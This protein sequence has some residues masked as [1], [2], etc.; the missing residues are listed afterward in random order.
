MIQ[1]EIIVLNNPWNLKVRYNVPENAA[2]LKGDCCKMKVSDDANLI[3]TVRN[4]IVIA[5]PSLSMLL[6]NNSKAL[7]LQPFIIRSATSVDHYLSCE[8]V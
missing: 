1:I 3:K 6:L 5:D 7:K 4:D 2:K 8:C